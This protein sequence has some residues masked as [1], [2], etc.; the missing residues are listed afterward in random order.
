MTAAETGRGSAR[1]TCADN[2]VI[3]VANTTFQN[4]YIRETPSFNSYLVIAP[5]VDYL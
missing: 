3:S 4:Q 1:V 2:A 5:W